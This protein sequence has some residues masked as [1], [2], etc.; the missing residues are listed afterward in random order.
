MDNSRTQREHPGSGSSSRAAQEPFEDEATLAVF[1]GREF[2]VALTEGLRRARV[3]SR[4]TVSGEGAPAVRRPAPAPEGAPGG[5][6]LAEYSGAIL[7]RFERNLLAVPAPGVLA[8]RGTRV[9]VARWAGRVLAAAGRT[10]CPGGG[11]VPPFPRGAASQH[12]VAISLLIES[13]AHTL[14]PQAPRCLEVIRALARAGGPAG[15]GGTGA[16]GT[17]AGGTGAARVVR[18][19][20]SLSDLA[21]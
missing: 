5:S 20:P 15:A 2:A 14:P 11:D 6:L 8:H 16:G 21:G 17:G 9:S 19:G 12:A 10:P 1:V 18:A 3:T 13:A 4:T 7:R